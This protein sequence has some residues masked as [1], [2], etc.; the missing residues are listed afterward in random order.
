MKERQSNW[1]P[2]HACSEK[3]ERDDR[4]IK[5]RRKITLDFYFIIIFR[6]IKNNN[7]PPE[8]Y[9]LLKSI[10]RLGDPNDYKN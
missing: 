7:N 6:F 1:S 5:E 9:S 2:K 8:M 4:K 10:Q 3:I